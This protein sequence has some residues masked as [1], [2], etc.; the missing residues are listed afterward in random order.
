MVH[1]LFA[2]QALSIGL[3]FAQGIKNSKAMAKY[4]QQLQDKSV[5]NAAEFA[6]SSYEATQA[7][8]QQIEASLAQE[9]F[10][11]R[12]EARKAAATEAVN[13]T[14]SGVTGLSA[15]D[16]LQQ[17]ASKL[18]ETIGTSDLQDK[19]NKAQI[20]REMAAIKIQQQNSIYLGDPVQEPSAFVAAG[21]IFGAY[22]STKAAFPE[23]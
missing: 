10:L 3:D 9:Q 7:R 6:S 8:A 16:V 21:S 17:F 1:P 15:Q 4:Q 22:L 11:T 18:S 20:G 13:A 2:M 5:E 19:Y 14:E 12:R 23:V